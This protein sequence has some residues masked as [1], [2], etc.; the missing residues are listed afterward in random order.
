MN[1]ESY[2]FVNISAGTVTFEL[3]FAKMILPYVDKLRILSLVILHGVS[4]LITVWLFKG[5]FC[6]YACGPMFHYSTSPCAEAKYM[7]QHQQNERWRHRWNG[8]VFLQSDIGIPWVRFVREKMF[9]TFPLL[10]VFS[11]CSMERFV[12][13]YSVSINSRRYVLNTHGDINCM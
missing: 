10:C 7:L 11:R 9:A 1:Y 6:I 5:L 3:F 2:Q 4:Y 13:V 12:I 8:N